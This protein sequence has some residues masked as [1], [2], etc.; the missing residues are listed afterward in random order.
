MDLGLMVEGFVELTENGR[1]VLRIPRANGQ[2]EYLDIQEQVLLHLGKEV[3]LICTPL[4]VIAKLA[5]MVESGEV[6]L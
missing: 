5:K 3:R 4:E 6:P 1:V 2:N